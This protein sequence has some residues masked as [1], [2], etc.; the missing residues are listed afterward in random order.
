MHIPTLNFKQPTPALGSPV[1]QS[2]PAKAIAAAAP[3]ATVEISSAA[4]HAAT[5]LARQPENIIWGN[6]PQR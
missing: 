2:S 1:R 5:T 3:A 6:G 4:Q